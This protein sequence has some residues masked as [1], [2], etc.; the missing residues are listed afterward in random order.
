MGLL[1]VTPSRPH[2]PPVPEYS[3][4]AAAGEFLLCG[5]VKQHEAVPAKGCAGGALPCHIQ[6]SDRALPLFE[7][8]LEPAAS[9]VSH[10]SGAPGVEAKLKL[11]CV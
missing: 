8:P 5:E 1:S 3:L 9:L 4:P 11:G 10:P 7:H 6:H 2:S